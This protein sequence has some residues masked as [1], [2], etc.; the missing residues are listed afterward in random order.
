MSAAIGQVFAFECRFS[1]F[2]RTVN[3]TKAGTARYQY[4]LDIRESYPDATFADI[5]VR[6]IGPAHSSD[7][8]LR[9]AT[10]RGMPELRCGEEVR[11]SGRRGFVVGH[12]DSANFDVLFAEGEWAGAVLNCHPNDIKRAKSEGG[13]NV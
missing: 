2:T 11:V 7:A 13:G 4:L 10:Y 6:K 3:A 9:T 5:R 8:F 1:D 12:N